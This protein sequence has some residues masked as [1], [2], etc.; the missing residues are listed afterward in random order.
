MTLTSHTLVIFDVE[1]HYSP[2]A[3]MSLSDLREQTHALSTF[4]HAITEL[5]TVI[6]RRLLSMNSNIPEVFIMCIFA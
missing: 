5:L 3:N 2:S 6:L 4:K 1:K